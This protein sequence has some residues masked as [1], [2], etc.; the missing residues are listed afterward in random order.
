[1][2]WLALLF[3]VACGSAVDPGPNDAASTADV[4]TDGG[5]CGKVPDPSGLC[6]YIDT[7]SGLCASTD[8]G[9]AG[10]E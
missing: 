9:D 2:R 4:V 1:M 6:V 5:K 10:G 8:A 7:C 3:L